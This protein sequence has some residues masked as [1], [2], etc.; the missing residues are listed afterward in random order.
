M[1]H[2]K[3]PPH[4]FPTGYTH[5]IFTITPHLSICERESAAGE[6][7]AGGGAQL[8]QEPLVVEGSLTRGPAWA[9]QTRQALLTTKD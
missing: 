6:I 9:A 7:P 4:L 1:R 8:D 3:T 5:R 2:L